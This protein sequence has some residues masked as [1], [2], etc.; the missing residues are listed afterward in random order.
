M[1]AMSKLTQSTKGKTCIR[2]GSP[3]AYSCH[4][5][6]PMQHAYGKGRGIKCHDIATAEFC[7]E[8]DQRFSEGS[9]FREQWESRWERSEEFLHWIMMT[10]IRRIKDGDL[11]E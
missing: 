10:N 9:T 11:H 6:G 2:C 5:N 7:H 4:Y 1:W 8:C 3:D